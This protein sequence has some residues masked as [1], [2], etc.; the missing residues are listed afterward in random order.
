MSQLE[1]ASE[2]RWP[3][4]AIAFRWRGHLL[5]EKLSICFRME[6]LDSV[7]HWQILATDPEIQTDQSILIE[8]RT[9][10]WVI[11]PLNLIPSKFFDPKISQLRIPSNVMIQISSN[12]EGILKDREQNKKLFSIVSEDPWISDWRMPINSPITSKFGGRRIAPNGEPYFH[13]GVDLR[14]SWNTPVMA[15][16]QGTVIGTDEQ[17]VSGNTITIDHGYG[18]IT[19]YLHLARFLVKQGD[20]V[21]AGTVIGLSGATGRVEAPHL[22]WEIRSRGHPVDPLTTFRLLEHL[23]YSE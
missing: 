14:A 23:A 15:A 17:V 9:K 16:S 13:S 4:S 21:R 10:N 19:R 2:S 18:L 6:C 12:Q 20:K 5:N 7:P 3:G 11:L 22:H 8:D 1:F